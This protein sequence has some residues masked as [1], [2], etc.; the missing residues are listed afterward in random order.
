MLQQTTVGAVANRY[1]AFVRRF[2]NVAALARA[3]EESVLAA[4]SGLGYYAR[5]RNLR[6]AARVV[7]KEHGGR[8]PQDPETLRSLPGFGE[9]M[10]AAV[11]SLAF[12]ARVPAAEANVTR[13][14][15]RLRALRE[16]AGSAALRRTVLSEAQRLLPRRDPGRLLAALMDLGQTVCTPRRPA[17]PRCPVRARCAGYLRGEPEAFP[18]RRA[19]PPA[20]HVALAAAYVAS[21]G[22]A[23]LER[24]T[25]KLLGGL[26]EFPSATGESPALARRRLRARLRATGIALDSNGPVGR[27]AHTVVNRKLAIEVFRT[28][29]DPSRRSA[30]APGPTWRWFRP[31]ELSRAA[32]PTLTRKIGL[33]A[34]F[35][36]GERGVS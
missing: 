12:R 36:G 6:R 27:A 22:R 35:L 16:R 10:A 2:P 1:A 8:I 19:K 18:A 33:A 21:D 4:W 30:F 11:A 14:V 31:G 15:A 25:E 32:I 29:L 17:C 13:V 7:M 20:R 23:L 9:Y 28:R 24:R 34:G 5:A 3:R 26:W